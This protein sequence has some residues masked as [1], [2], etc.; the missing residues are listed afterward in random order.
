MNN[1]REAPPQDWPESAFVLVGREDLAS[2]CNKRH[3]H[4]NVSQ[5][6]APYMLHLRPI[7]MFSSETD[8]YESANTESIMTVD[9]ISDGMEN[10]FNGTAQLRFGSDLR[11]NE[12]QNVHCTEVYRNE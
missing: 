10:L 12:V 7:S 3:S 8:T 1:C 6:A 4:V 9:N 2:M 5:M 11:L